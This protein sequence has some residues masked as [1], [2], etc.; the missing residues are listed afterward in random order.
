MLIADLADVLLLTVL[1]ISVFG[2]PEFIAGLAVMSR[3]LLDDVT[4]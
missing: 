3:V 1:L 2:P 4:H